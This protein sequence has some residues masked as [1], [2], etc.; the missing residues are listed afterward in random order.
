[1]KREREKKEKKKRTERRERKSRKSPGKGARGRD[2]GESSAIGNS[3]PTRY[4]S[5]VQLYENM[6]NDI[7]DQGSKLYV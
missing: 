2:K 6:T 3:R 5:E 4:K 1:M 7:F